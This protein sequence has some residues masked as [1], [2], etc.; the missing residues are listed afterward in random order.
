MG[1][2]RTGHLKA[3]QPLTIGICMQPLITNLPGFNEKKEWKDQGLPNH[4][5]AGKCL[6]INH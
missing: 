6:Q 5:V 1:V 4:P 2:S 3:G